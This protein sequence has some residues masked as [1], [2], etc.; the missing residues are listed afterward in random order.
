MKSVA[1]AMDDWLSINNESYIAITT[2][3]LNQHYSLESIRLE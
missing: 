2:Y 3:F 1:I